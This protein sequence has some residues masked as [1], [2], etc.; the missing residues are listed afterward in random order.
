MLIAKL[1]LSTQALWAK[2][3]EP[4]G[5]PLLLHMLDV[6][7]VAEAL[8]HREPSATLAW[9]AAPFGLPTPC[10]LRWLAALIG[11][12]DFGKAV[13]GFQAKWDEG[14]LA[15]LRAALTFPPVALAR[16]RHDIATVATLRPHLL[17][18]GLD[19]DWVAAVL[20]AIGAHHG[21]TLLHDDI[22]NGRPILEGE[23]WP[24][25]R[26][27]LFD[28]YWSTLAPAGR[29]A[30]D[31]IPLP[32]IAWLAGL[33]SVCDWIGSNTDWFPPG[34]RADTLAAHFD[35]ARH[36]AGTALDAIGWDAAGRLLGDAPAQTVDT[37]LARILRRTVPIAAR[38]LQTTADRLLEQGAGPALML[39]EAP[40]GEGKT[41]L[42]FLAH[43]R[44]QARNG[45]RG[46][47]VALPTQ[48]TGNAMF[49]RT[50]DFLH[51]FAGELRLDIQLAHGGAL[52]DERV[53]R[54][55]NLWGDPRNE[56]VS[57]S[58][59]F[60]KRRRA[61]LSPYGV[62]TIDQALFATLNVKHHF[63]RLWG[64]ANRVIVLDEVHAYD[65]YTSGL[66]ESLLRWLKALGCSVIL[67]SAT[68]PASKR[69][70]LF[71]AWGVRGEAPALAYPRVLLADAHGVRGEHFGARQQPPIRVLG[72]DEALETL[73]EQALHR[74]EAGG[75]GAIIVNTV[76]RA[77]RLYTRLRE[78]CAALGVELLLFHARFPADERQAH[79]QRV[80]QRFGPPDARRPRPTRALLI[81]TQVAEQSL[82]IDFDF[83]IS[84]LAPID[85]L[86]QRAGRLHRHQ[87]P[88]RPAAHRAPTLFIAG[89]VTERL[90]ELE[91][92]AWKAVYGAY[93]CLVTWAL[94]RNEPL[95]RLPDD[96]DR[97]VQ[98]VY[99]QEP[100]LDG[101]AP[102]HAR[103]IADVAR[104]EHKAAADCSRQMAKNV[105][106]DARDEADTAYAGKPHGRDEDEC[107]GLRNRTRLGEASVS[108]VPLFADDAGHWRLSPT[109]APLPPGQPADDALARRLFARQLKLSRRGVVEALQQQPRP[110][111]FTE[112]PLT[113]NLLPLPLHDGQCRLGRHLL[114]LD[115]ELGLC[116]H[117]DSPQE[118]P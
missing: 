4:H 29:A 116:Y 6:A 115:P 103:Y 61:L 35:D 82:D 1:P 89:L 46:L 38:P 66:I 57:S 8:L 111:L 31:D 109:E 63:V 25:A 96:I 107:F 23:A 81:A 88:E 28:A 44:L 117:T 87:R 11:L 67:M 78:P 32:A 21:F 9:T 95:W 71:E 5:H 3:G 100:Q 49:D 113:A 55:R 75:C 97:L 105:A 70:A 18:L 33:T 53:A 48:A 85:L 19:P 108:V 2:S 17:D 101:L 74:L 84:D 16:D 50:L 102:E 65:T 73:A 60:S 92:T 112:H 99:A 13:P 68:L 58:A 27:D 45:H 90:P 98:A 20:Q 91:T 41:E 59:W 39:V 22:K 12:H 42:A 118:Q 24:Q 54:L 104:M 72:V 14:R 69:Q 110:A 37:L 79:E 83:L 94:L 93:L 10:A 15:C 47:Y 106:L 64:L 7:A 43:L 36:R 76:D 26:Q 77:Q 34:A 62:G 40:M 56:P 52:L 80:L 114:R 30:A 51:A 86:L